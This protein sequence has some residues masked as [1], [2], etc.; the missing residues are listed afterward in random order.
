MEECLYDFH[1]I[2]DSKVLI[3][4]KLEIVVNNRGSLRRFLLLFQY[5]ILR[6]RW[7][8]S[9]LL[10]FHPGPQMVSISV[11]YALVD[12]KFATR[13]LLSVFFELFELILIHLVPKLI[14][15]KIH[16]LFVLTHLNE[17][18]RAEYLPQRPI[19]EYIVEEYGRVPAFIS[20]ISGLLIPQALP[21]SAIVSLL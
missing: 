19:L 1:I 12:R 6:R 14:S 9:H 10:H 5:T 2:R 18:L 20:R 21:L 16:Y 7:I 4:T 15:E 3:L 13:D 8:L 17:L 11:V